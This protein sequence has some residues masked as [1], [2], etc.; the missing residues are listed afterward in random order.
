MMSIQSKRLEVSRKLFEIAKKQYYNK[1]I[2]KKE[3]L[4]TL[5]LILTKIQ[6]E[7]LEFDQVKF[8]ESIFNFPSFKINLKETINYTLSMN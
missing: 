1:K 8:L 7:E 6:N 3:Y 2:S 5:E 4:E